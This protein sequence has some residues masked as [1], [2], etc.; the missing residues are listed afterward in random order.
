MSSGG[1]KDNPSLAL[2]NNLNSQK[3]SGLITSEVHTS[4]PNFI[5]DLVCGSD[6]ND[7]DME[8]KKVFLSLLNKL[9]CILL[10][11]KNLT[12]LQKMD[13]CSVERFLMKLYLKNIIKN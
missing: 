3:L 2:K 1:V 12:I 4:D 5:I 7:E 6:I 11:S 10:S 8:N 9:R 13:C